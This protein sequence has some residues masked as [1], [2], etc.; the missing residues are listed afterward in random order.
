[1][2]RFLGCGVLLIVTACSGPA[3]TTDAGGSLDA[4]PAPGTDGAVV[5]DAPTT[6]HDAGMGPSDGGS[7]QG[8]I[9]DLSASAVN[10]AILA[11][12]YTAVPGATGYEERHATAGS[13]SWSSPAALSSDR[14]TG[15]AASTSYD[16]QIRAVTASGN[17]GWSN[18]ATQS[19]TAGLVITVAFDS[20]ASAET[21]YQAA[22][23]EAAANIESLFAPTIT[24]GIHFGWGALGGHT[25]PSP[26][27]AVANNGGVLYLYPYATVRTAI[28]DRAYDANAL[29]AFDSLPASDP[30]TGTLEVGAANAVAIGLP[31][32]VS[33]GGPDATCWVA[34]RELADLGLHAHRGHSSRPLR[35][36]RGADARDQRMPR[37]DPDRWNERQR[38]RATRS[39]LLFCAP[40]ARLAFRWRVCVGG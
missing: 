12:T 36:R 2:R 29:A 37:Q 22:A 14:V 20:S 39:L 33:F 16:V 32:P 35:L 11:L 24:V 40:H 38:V 21:G 15:L 4:G 6:G 30:T 23:R 26:V 28:G 34:V 31:P 5:A 13:G 1:M 27:T 9:T 18:T 10:G 8:D 7:S 17:G 19:T 25:P 3:T